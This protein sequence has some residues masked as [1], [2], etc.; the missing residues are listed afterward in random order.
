MANGCE[1]GR[2]LVVLVCLRRLLVP[3]ADSA[4]TL[5]VFAGCQ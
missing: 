1:T 2:T 3:L 4:M 5:V